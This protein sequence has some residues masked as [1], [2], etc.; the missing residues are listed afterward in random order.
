MG[1]E[2]LVLALL[3]I[4]G[5][6]IAEAFRRWLEDRFKEAAASLPPPSSYATDDEARDALFNEVLR[7]TR[8]PLKRVMLRRMKGHAARLGVVSA[9]SLT[10]AVP[11]DV[12][13]E[14]AEL[15]AEMVAAEE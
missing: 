15:S 7:R 5:P 6:L 14:F 9:D 12:A 11:P 3:Q 8:N 4:F 10:V 13:A 1:W 2:S